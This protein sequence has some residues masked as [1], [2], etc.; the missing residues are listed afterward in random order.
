MVGQQT[1]GHLGLGF[2]RVWGRLADSLRSIAARLARPP[3]EWGRSLADGYQAGD[4]PASVMRAPV[5]K[6][7]YVRR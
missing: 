2:G 7:P 6:K 1:V 3:Y 5:S 4:S